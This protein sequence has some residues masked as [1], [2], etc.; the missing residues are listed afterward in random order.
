MAYTSAGLSAVE[1]IGARL[2]RT[3]PTILPDFEPQQIY[4]QSTLC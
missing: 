4:H 2:L 3:G 1:P